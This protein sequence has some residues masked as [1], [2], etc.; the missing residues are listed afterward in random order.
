MCVI[1]I[2]FSLKFDPMIVKIIWKC[3]EKNQVT[4]EVCQPK[5]CEIYFRTRQFHVV[6]G[7]Q[8]LKLFSCLQLLEG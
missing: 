2:F 5:N 1:D 8:E 6:Y 3:E 4:I 7:I